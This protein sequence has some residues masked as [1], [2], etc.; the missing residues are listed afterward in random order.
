MHARSLRTLCGRVRSLHACVHAQRPLL[1][2]STARRLHNGLPCHQGMKLWHI[3]HQGLQPLP[4]R[5]T[6]AESTL[7]IDDG[8]LGS[9]KR[10]V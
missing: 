1:A 9:L 7:A 5:S 8:G 2:I 10:K 6:A 4:C 3:D